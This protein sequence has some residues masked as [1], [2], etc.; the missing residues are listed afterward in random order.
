MNIIVKFIKHFFSEKTRVFLYNFSAPYF[1]NTNPKNYAFCGSNVDLNGPLYLDPKQVYLENHTRLQQGIRIISNK[2]KLHVK[3]FTAIGANCVIIPGAHTPTV[4]LPQYLST[5]HIN[6]IDREIVIEED[7]WIGAGSFLLSHCHIGRGAIVAASSVVTKEI[8][9]YAV[10][11]GSPAKIIACRFSIEQI[12]KHEASLYPPD[13]RM[14]KEKLEDIFH[15]Y[16]TDL[17]HI[18]KDLINNNDLSLLK[19][20]KEQK[21]ITIY[22]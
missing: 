6:D 9:P 5:S 3:E 11:A 20:I 10:V 1:R 4:G 2:G 21:Q 22:E 8:P 19:T 13:K 15:T 16:Y 7:C 17:R 12:L 18:G 14:K